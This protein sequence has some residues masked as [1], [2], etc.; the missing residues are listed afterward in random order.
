LWF[1]MKHSALDV[2]TDPAAVVFVSPDNKLAFRYNVSNKVCTVCSA[3]EAYIPKGGRQVEEICPLPIPG[4]TNY[5]VSEAPTI[6]PVADKLP[7]VLDTTVRLRGPLSILSVIL[8]YGVGYQ[9]A[10][11]PPSHDGKHRNMNETI[12]APETPRIT[13]YYREGSSDKV[14]QASIE[15]QAEGFVVNIAYGRRGSTMTTGTKTQTPVDYDTAKNIYGRLIRE[16]MAKKFRL[17]NM[18]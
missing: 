6:L 1:V 16:K 8:G 4:L 14:Y 11:K 3:G 17:G 7:A 9:L 13:L 10:Q 12:T 18:V 2:R 5:M 15:P